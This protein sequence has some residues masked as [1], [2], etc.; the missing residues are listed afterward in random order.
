[1]FFFVN[2][3]LKV[4]IVFFKVKHYFGHISGMVGAIDVKEKGSAPV[5][6]W[7]YYVTLTLDLTYDLDLGFCKITF[8]NSCIS[9]IVGLIDVK[10]KGSKLIRYRTDHMTFPFDHTHDLDLEVS[11]SVFEIPLSQEWTGWLTLN[12]RVVSHPCMAMILTFCGHGG[13][14]GWTR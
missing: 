3:L 10:W 14:G 1:M 5:G 7:V 12:K 13:V 8:W 4:L 2:F 6:Y 9:G 11:R